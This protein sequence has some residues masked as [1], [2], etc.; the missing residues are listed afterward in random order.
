LLKTLL[1]SV[2]VVE[3][4]PFS[5]ISGLYI[6]G[7]QATLLI[8]VIFLLAVVILF[9]S[10]RCYPILCLLVLVFEWIHVTHA[11]H[12]DDQRTVLISAIKG[13]TAINLING[14]SAVLLVN[15]GKLP[16]RN[17]LAYAFSNFWI[18]H[19]VSPP[20][21]SLDSLDTALCE[22]RTIPG[23]YCRPSWRGSN[24]LIT[25]NEQRMILLRD[26]RFYRFHSKQPLQADYI[27]IT[28]G[29][30]VRPEQIV[31]EIKFKMLI[32]DGSVIKSRLKQWKLAC[33]KG[34]FACHV[35]PEQGAFVIT[36]PQ[37]KFH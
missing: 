2:T 24:I 20:V 23:L 17:N 26:N 6:N 33:E 9:K 8:L 7:L 31:E 36:D 19:G 16:D 1:L 11:K 4:L 12:L 10:V 28:G 34:G 3:K 37:A 22:G 30:S 32:M 5:L 29:L 27:L 18:R 35:I 21:I 25:F 14:K 13:T 15:D